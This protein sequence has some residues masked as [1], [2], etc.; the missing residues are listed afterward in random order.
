[1]SFTLVNAE[2]LM[3][4]VVDTGDKHKVAYKSAKLK[5]NEIAFVGYSVCCG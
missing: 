2:Q 3:A 4:V 1:V 5:K